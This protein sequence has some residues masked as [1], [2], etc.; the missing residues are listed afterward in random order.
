MQHSWELSE[1]ASPLPP[2]GL[3]RVQDCAAAAAA[4]GKGHLLMR[5]QAQLRISLPMPRVS[6]SLQLEGQEEPHSDLTR[7]HDYHP[8]M[9]SLEPNRDTGW[10]VCLWPRVQVW[11]SAVAHDGGWDL[12]HGTLSVTWRLAVQLR[13]RGLMGSAG[14]CGSYC[15]WLPH[16]VPA[17]IPPTIICLQRIWTRHSSLFASFLWTQ[18]SSSSEAVV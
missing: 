7:W 13:I 16:R 9:L 18:W 12:C 5:A 17:W 1:H 6:L 11:T 15:F 10:A 14:M 3:R 4:G 8:K 2:A